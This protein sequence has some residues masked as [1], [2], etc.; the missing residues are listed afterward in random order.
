MM[1]K[2]SIVTLPVVFP[3]V[4]VGTLLMFLITDKN[5]SHY[6]VK[7]LK[8]HHEIWRVFPSI[9]DKAMAANIPPVEQKDENSS[10]PAEIV[11][12]DLE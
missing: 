3:I 8:N 1:S 7:K 9:E 10:R 6:F 2:Y 5:A 4:M 11:V 12:I